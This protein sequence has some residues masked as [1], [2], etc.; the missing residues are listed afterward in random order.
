MKK[1]IPL[2]FIAFFSGDLYAQQSGA[3]DTSRRRQLPAGADTAR[4]RMMPP[5]IGTITPTRETPVHDPV[6]IKQNDKYYLFC[7]GPGISVFSS[8]DMKNWRKEKQ[9]FAQTPEW[10]V[11]AIPR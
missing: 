6:M 5:A 10:V 8:K 2:F 7:T 9:V 3:T 1:I 4:R 11:K